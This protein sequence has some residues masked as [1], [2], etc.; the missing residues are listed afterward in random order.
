MHAVFCDQLQDCLPKAGH[1]A[2]QFDTGQKSRYFIATM[3]NKASKQ[4]QSSQKKQ[5]GKTKQH[6]KHSSLLYIG[7][8][9]ILVIIIVTFIGGPLASSQGDAGLSFGSYNGKDIRYVQDSHFASLVELY[10]DNFGHRSLGSDSEFN[11]ITQLVWSRAFDD[12]VTFLASLDKAERSGILVASTQIDEEIINSPRFQEEDGTFLLER[13]KNTPNQDLFEMKR[14][15]NESLMVDQLITDIGQEA[16]ISSNEVE[17]L[18]EMNDVQKDIHLIEFS[19]DSFPDEQVTAW[20]TENANLTRRRSLSSITVNDELEAVQKIYD[21]VALS[22]ESFEENAR[23]YST[24]EFSPQGGARGEIYAFELIDLLAEEDVASLFDDALATGEI[25]GILPIK[26]IENSY[27]FFRASDDTTA[28]DPAD[29]DQLSS[30]RDYITDYHPERVSNYVTESAASFVAAAQDSSF[31]AAALNQGL[32]YVSLDSVPMA[33]GTD[34]IFNTVDA[35]EHP[36]LFTAFQRDNFLKALFQLDASEISEPISVRDSVLVFSVRDVSP[37]PLTDVLALEEDYTSE[38]VN[39]RQGQLE[40]FVVDD[41]L[42]VNN[43]QNVFDQHIRYEPPVE[44][45][46]TEQESILEDAPTEPIP[47]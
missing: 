40:S 5:A 31:I 36:I 28:F 25:S 1:K 45:A 30:F 46:A 15:L 39:Y 14:R 29:T 20:A 10:N 35:S 44:E 34:S 24:D 17:Y 13:Y 47:E 6:F 33:Y 19:P 11:L 21:T 32:E 12:T 4:Q 22:P 2:R 43:F 7:S 27:V 9:V 23:L 8:V 42:L 26:D 38:V 37:T 18:Q 41:D 3:N 16:W